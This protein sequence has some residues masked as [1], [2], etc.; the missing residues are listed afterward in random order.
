M[1]L[2]LPLILVLEQPT[3]LI[4]GIPL[5]LIVFFVWWLHRRKETQILRTDL[6]K[7]GFTIIN[8]GSETFDI[9]QF[10]DRSK[11]MNQ[12]W[13]ARSYNL[14]LHLQKPGVDFYDLMMNRIPYFILE[15]SLGIEG[16][17]S[18]IVDI[19]PKG[20]SFKLRK[21]LPWGLLPKAPFKSIFEKEA[22]RS[23]VSIFTD[24]IDT[25]K[26]KPFADKILN[27]TEFL[28]LLD[29]DSIS[30]E[31]FEESKARFYLKYIDLT[32]YETKAQNMLNLIPV[33]IKIVGE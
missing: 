5:G 30:I 27:D 29:Q 16:L 22:D 28:S 8:P 19:F 23:M 18:F 9:K 26:V 14:E 25:D 6:T 11:Y 15:V 3:I 13:A 12:G 1:E 31:I 32:D 10:I 21:L 17:P 2:L 7:L 24:P 20:L 4:I 33:L